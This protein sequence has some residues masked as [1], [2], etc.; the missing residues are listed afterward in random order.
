MTEQVLAN[1]GL[2]A[3]GTL[4]TLSLLKKPAATRARVL[5]VVAPNYV[6]VAGSF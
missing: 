4:I 2:A 1:V 3:G 6:G 5:P